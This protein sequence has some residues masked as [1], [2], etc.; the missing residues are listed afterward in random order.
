MKMLEEEMGEVKAL[1]NQ[2]EE[3]ASGQREDKKSWT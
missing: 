2:L 3:F 1:L